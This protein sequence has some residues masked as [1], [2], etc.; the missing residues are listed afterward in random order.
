MIISDLIGIIADDLTGANDAAL[1]F[2]LRGANAQVLLDFSNKPDTKNIQAWAFSTATRNKAPEEAFSVISEATLV[3]KNDFNL[4]YFFKK[5][6]S[7]IRGQIAVETLAMIEALEWDAAMIVPA[8]PCSGK[9]TVGGYQLLDGVPIERTEFGLDPRFPVTESH[10]PTLLKNQLLNKSPEL[11]GTIDLLNVIK[12]AGPILVELNELIKHGKKLIVADAVSTTDIEQIV[13]AMKKSNY[14]ILPVGTCA[15]AQILGNIW[16]S[17]ITKEHALKTVPNLPKLIMSGSCDALGTIQIE[18]LKY[19]EFKN[20]CFIELDMHMILEG[21]TGEIIE[22]VLSGLNSDNITVVHASNLLNNFDGFSDTSFYEEMT[23]NKLLEK[24]VDYLAILTKN[25]VDKREVIL[26]TLG[27]ETS[28]RCCEA[29]DST[30]LRIVDEIVPQIP[31]TADYK[32]RYIVAK[33][34][35]IGTPNSLVDILNYF[36]KHRA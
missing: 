27:G 28:Y 21:V 30:S 19:S 3:L 15:M 5:I 34:G 35:Y 6:D 9:I 14:K 10:V 20:V 29:I 4:D 16:L 36:E 17:G 31:L 32:D 22:R 13:L 12:G 8:Y 23:K 2:Q 24:I 33:S 1:Q 26:V 11:I 18:A 7:S 25:V